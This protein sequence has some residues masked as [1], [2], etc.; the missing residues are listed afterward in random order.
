M[1]SHRLCHILA[2]LLP[3][4]AISVAGAVGLLTWAGTNAARADDDRTVDF[5]RDV[6]PILS[7]ACWRCH[8]FDEEAR[9]A[10]LRLDTREGALGVADSG[11]RAIVPG[12]P[13]GSELFARVTAGDAE[14]RMP[15]PDSNKFLTTDQISILRRWI[16]EGA[17]YEAHWAFQQPH[18]TIPPR[19][20]SGRNPI[21]AFVAASF[22]DQVAGFAEEAS[23]ATL[24][25]RVSFDLTG[26]PPTIDDLECADESY[27]DFVDRLLAS[28]HF[29]ERMA[30]DWLDAARFADTNGYFGDKPRQ[31]WLWRD[32]VIAAFNSNAPFD[33]FT[34]EQIAGDLLPEATVSQRVA[35][36]FNR[37]HMVNDETGIIDEEFR[38]EYVIDRVDATMTTWLGLTVACAQC[39][40]HKYDPITQRDYYGLF[41]FFNDVP[42]KGLVEKQEPAPFL[43]VSTPEQDR[44]LEAL[45]RASAEAKQAFEALQPALLT[46]LRD[47]EPSG[48]RSLSEPPASGVVLHAPLDQ[49]TK[50]LTTGAELPD[51]EPGVVG[52]A[53]RF[54]ATRHVELDATHFD[55]DQAWTIGFWM[56]GDSSLACPLS[57]IE[58]DGD[59]RG[60]ELVWQKGRFQ[61]NLVS[62]WGVDLI[63][64]WSRDGFGRSAWHHVAVRYDGSRKASGLSLLIDGV[65]TALE[66]YSDSLTGSL[67]CH[68]PLRIGRR[69]AGLGYYGLLDEVRI[70]QEPLADDVIAAWQ[71]GERLR[72]ILDTPPDRRGKVEQQVLL[73]DFIDWHADEA[74]RSARRKLQQ[75]ETAERRL[76]DAIPTTLVMER[77]AEPRPTQVLERGQYDKPGQVVEPAV[78]EAFSGLAPDMPDNRLGFARWLVSDRSPLT[79]RVAVNRLW[80][81]CFGEGLVRTMNDFGV[82]GELPTHPELIDWLAL[83]FRDSGWDVKALL[84]L[85]VTSQTYRQRSEFRIADGQVVDPQNRWL[86]RGPSFRLSAEMIRDQALCSSGLLSPRVGGPSVKPYQPP[87]LWEEV[88]FNA[89]ETYVEGAGEDL[90]RRS[91]YT[92]QKR[93]APPPALLAFDGTTRE[94]CVV[95]RGR[96][97]TPIQAL[98][99]FNDPTYIE[100]ARV[101][102]QNGLSGPGTDE[103]RMDSAFQRV[104]SRRPESSERTLL[105]E[106]LARQRTRF[107]ANAADAAAVVAIGRAPV[108]ASLDP[109]E[110]AAWTVVLQ[111]LFNLDEAL[112]RR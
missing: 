103:Q 69:D 46:R 37:N 72:G 24:M 35:T 21:D 44:Q 28:P 57:L 55:P 5:N 65:P 51:V 50:S 101:L 70:V 53:M 71:R 52:Q 85:I 99:V 25:R 90:W 88:S 104:L 107:D 87:G 10:G 9:Q 77:M 17:N 64:A 98:I 49:T 76:R 59:R 80:R 92:F 63:E 75:A 86:A 96:T 22:P 82:Q 91:L 60:I 47:W 3:Q 11:P 34:I 109:G 94:K 56:Q 54:D 66:I 61:I 83:R 6:R 111:T 12:Q 100:A 112:T 41:A 38:V 62:R 73:E 93:Q 1:N 89:E 19:I 108:D 67:R 16:E 36:G 58:P 39:H 32:W 30:V 33:Q 4:F 14:L 68:E 27:E 20:S 74:A 42:E 13:D 31:V 29:G 84:R 95:Q 79:A 23:R 15:P 102:A 43:S 40:D 106:L 45:S 105:V 2:M 7:D 48:A 110:L 8:G 78:P 18:V 26:L 97:N 81:Q